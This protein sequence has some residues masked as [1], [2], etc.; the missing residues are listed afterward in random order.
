MDRDFKVLVA[1]VFTLLTLACIRAYDY[2]YIVGDLEPL[3]VLCDDCQKAE[4]YF[5]SEEWRIENER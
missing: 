3:Q 5:M 4:Y 2:I 1:I